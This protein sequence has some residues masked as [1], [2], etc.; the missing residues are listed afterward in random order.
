L[1][2]ESLPDQ[3]EV[4]HTFGYHLA[5]VPGHHFLNVAAYFRGGPRYF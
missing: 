4:I 3:I 2:W 1:S 5:L